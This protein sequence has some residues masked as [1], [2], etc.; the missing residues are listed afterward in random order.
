MKQTKQN[1]TVTLQFRNGDWFREYHPDFL[2]NMLAEHLRKIKGYEAKR[3]EEL[4]IR[5]LFQ[6][7]SNVVV[8]N[9]L[10]KQIKKAINETQKSP[11]E[12]QLAAA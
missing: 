10:F 12:A 9:V 6:S 7:G 4:R 8:N 11:Q 3:L 2:S 5:M 1:N